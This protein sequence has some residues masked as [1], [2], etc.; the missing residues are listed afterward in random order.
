[1]RGEEKWKKK[2]SNKSRHIAANQRSLTYRPLKK[3]PLT[4]QH[5]L[6][7]FIFDHKI[8]I[9]IKIHQNIHPDV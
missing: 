5:D 6:E 9:Y 1:M 3:Y 8:V 7:I 2:Y 4:K